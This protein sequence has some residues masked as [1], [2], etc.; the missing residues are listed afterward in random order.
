VGCAL[1]L[2][3]FGFAP[4]PAAADWHLAPFAGIKFGGSTTLIDLEDNADGTKIVYGGTV[5]FV[6]RGLFGIEGDIGI[7]P[8]YLQNDQRADVKSSLVLTTMGNVV[9]AAPLGWTRDSLRPYVSGGAGLIRV[10][11]D[12]A[13][14]LLS[15][16]RTLG[17][18]NVGG[19]V[20]GF[21]TPFTGLKWDVRY[22]KAW[23]PG[24]EGRTLGSARI[25]FW[26]ATMA[27]VLRY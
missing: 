4:A 2:T 11:M 8:N 20:V 14:N 12:D 21:V 1:V 24:G 10:S 19:G 9:V 3:V 25:A 22:F 6:G 16:K 13:L 7:I 27:V 17:G 18:Y 15:Y 26:R 23:G 5:T